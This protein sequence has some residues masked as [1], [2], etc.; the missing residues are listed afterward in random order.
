MMDWIVVGLSTCLLVLVAL[1]LW[2]GDKAS[3][4][5][6]GADTS[7]AEDPGGEWIGTTWWPHHAS[8]GEAA[9]EADPVTTPADRARGG[10]D[11]LTS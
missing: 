1:Y 10:R 6:E 4:R 5:N 2:V 9:P 7:P 8:S 11:A 3:R